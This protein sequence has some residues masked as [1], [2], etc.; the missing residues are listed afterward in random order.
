MSDEQ[1]MRF[2]FF[3]RSHLSRSA[4]KEL[5]EKTIS[6]KYPVSDEMAIVV[7]GLAKLYIGELIETGFCYLYCL[8]MLSSYYNIVFLKKP[9]MQQRKVAI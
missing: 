3:V 6:N 4:V 9:Q 1:L 5:V 2:E 8:K 7:G